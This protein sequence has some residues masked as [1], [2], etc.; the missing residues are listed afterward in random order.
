MNK[1]RRKRDILKLKQSCNLVRLYLP[2]QEKQ[3][4]SLCLRGKKKFPSVT[5]LPSCS[6]FVLLFSS[7]NS[8]SN[9]KENVDRQVC[10]EGK[11]L[12]AFSSLLSVYSISYDS[13]R[14]LRVCSPE[15]GGELNDSFVL[16]F[17]KLSKKNEPSK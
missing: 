17:L 16:T 6:R 10:K 2:N 9:S 14:L 13:L 1:I 8:C 15:T 7:A 11:L 4:F 5:S 3:R 12:G